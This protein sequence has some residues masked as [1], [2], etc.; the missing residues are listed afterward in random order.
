MSESPWC[1]RHWRSLIDSAHNSGVPEDHGQ[2]G[3]GFDDET[4][5]AFEALRRRARAAVERA[6]EARDR[7][8][9]AQRVHALIQE[10]ELAAHELDGLRTAMRTRAT[11]EQPRA[12]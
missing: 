3:Q 6:Q 10:L 4:V 11:I 1:N 7:M 12:W 2:S 5:A 9:A 8:P